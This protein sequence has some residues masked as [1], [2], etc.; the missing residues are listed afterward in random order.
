MKISPLLMISEMRALG[1]R[2]RCILVLSVR[3]CVLVWN[4]KVAKALQNE[5]SFYKCLL[6]NRM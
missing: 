3:M 6:Y 5:A 2:Q 1:F 4:F